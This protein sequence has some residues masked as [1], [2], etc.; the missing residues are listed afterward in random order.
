MISNVSF[1]VALLA[2]GL[3]LFSITILNLT[4]IISNQIALSFLTI[5]LGVLPII[6]YFFSLRNKISESATNV[7]DHDIDSL[8]YLGFLVTLITLIFTVGVSVV[9]GNEGHVKFV[10]LGFSLSLIATAFALYGRIHLVQLKENSN[11]FNDDADKEYREKINDLINDLEYSYKKLTDVIES[12]INNLKN[13][14]ETTCNE[15]NKSATGAEESINILLKNASTEIK[16][17]GLSDALSE[18]TQNFKSGG[19]DLKKVSDV[20]KV[21]SEKMSKSSENIRSIDLG[22]EN[23]T[24]QINTFNES[25]KAAGGAINLSNIASFNDAVSNLKKMHESLS[26]SSKHAEENLTK[27]SETAVQSINLRSKEMQEATKILSDTFIALAK[28]LEK[29]SNQLSKNIS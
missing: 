17:S 1:G 6:A 7:T 21:A 12:A 23:L 29:T 14:S 26:K 10:A 18:V 9:R 27:V 11:I 8:Y 20:F 28:A 25:L 19:S 24:S 3:G 15:I 13:A 16:N 2:S 22:V 4:T 5:T